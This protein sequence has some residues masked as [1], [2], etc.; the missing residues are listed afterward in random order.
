MEIPARSTILDG[1]NQSRRHR[2]FVGD[3]WRCV[4]KPHGAVESRP[5]CRRPCGAVR[6]GP[7]GSAR[8]TIRSK[9]G[10]L[11][12]TADLALSSSRAGRDQHPATIVD[13]PRAALA[14]VPVHGTRLTW[15]QPLAP[16]HPLVTAPSSMGDRPTRW[17]IEGRSEPDECAR[18]PSASGGASG[19]VRNFIGLH[20]CQG[21]PSPCSGACVGVCTVG[22]FLASEVAALLHAVSRGDLGGPPAV[23]SRVLLGAVFG[24]RTA[25][26][27]SGPSDLTVDPRCSRASAAGRSLHQAAT[28]STHRRV[29]ASR[30]PPP[31]APQRGGPAGHPLAVSTT[32]CPGL[33]QGLPPQRVPIG[34]ALLRVSSAVYPVHS[35]AEGGPLSCECGSSRSGG[36]SPAGGHRDHPLQQESSAAA[37]PP[38]GPAGGDGATVSIHRLA[39]MLKGERHVTSVRASL[40][41]CNSFFLVGGR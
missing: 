3:R 33:A 17:D 34:V 7:H 8:A 19:L 37:D 20:G 13:A 24:R 25:A 2:P 40:G 4:P 5:P 18:Q 15:G 28:D 41:A 22:A 23:I 32:T 31:I 1:L 35:G 16:G 11:Q 9:T 39:S 30:A 26:R 38:G 29:E 6:S 10:G 14:A 36:S 12:R 27:P 21:L